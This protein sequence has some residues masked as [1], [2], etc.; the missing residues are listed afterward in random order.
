MDIVRFARTC[1]CQ[2][3]EKGSLIYVLAC[4]GGAAAIIITCLQHAFGSG[5]T[6]Y[7]IILL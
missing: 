2:V 1:N 6:P 4:L 3:N 5:G 7:I